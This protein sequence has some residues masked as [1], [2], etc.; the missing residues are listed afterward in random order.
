MANQKRT[1]VSRPETKL[2]N[3]F[4]FW[5]AFGLVFTIAAIFAWNYR[6]NWMRD[7]PSNNSER[8]LASSANDDKDYVSLSTFGPTIENKKSAPA[9]RPEGMVFIPGG[10]FSMGCESKNE[11][12]C[13]TPGVTY[14]AGPIHRVYVD[15][16]W[17]DA[18]EVTNRQFQK[19]VEETG[20]VTIAEIKPTALE[21]PGAAEENL[22]TGSIVFSPT[23]SAVSLDDYLNWWSYVPG[24]DWKHPL[25]P[26]SSIEGKEDEP[27]VH[28][29][30]DD[31][32]AYCK[33]AGKRLPTEAEWEFAA[34][35]G[36][37]GDL[38]TWGNQ[39]S[40]DG[41]YQANIYQ[42]AFPVIAG[43]TAVD[44][45]AGIAPVKQYKPNP[46]GLYDM[47]GNVWEWASD[48]YR[49]DYYRTL[50]SENKVAK[51]PQGPSNSFDPVEPTV[52]K[53]VHRGGS[54]LCSDLYC[55]R[56]LLGTRGKGDERS[57]SNHVGFRCVRDVNP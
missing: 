11:S 33:W 31:A 16:F 26:Q 51:N 22:V 41:M 24:A 17:M 20:Y 6:P 47:S 19:F 1:R 7:T 49:P 32:I 10:E 37:A 2:K 55:N 40:S 15:P 38:Y 29:A 39:L 46:Y 45:F 56:Y 21:F 30:F 42:G 54:F 34:R 3:A 23:Q 9:D 13:S 18:T 35:G 44:G 53:R 4:V 12:L 14:D 25:G 43:D 52:A 28:I 5:V 27:V 8:E 57:A 36:I 50:K 48:W